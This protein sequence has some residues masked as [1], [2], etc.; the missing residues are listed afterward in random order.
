[1]MRK[2]G[3]IGYLLI[4]VLVA[5]CLPVEDLP[6]E[7]EIVFKSF[8]QEGT[9]ATLV[10]GFTD[11]DG[12]I[13]LEQGDTLGVN[14]PDTCIYYW[15]LFCEYY[16]LQD[17]EWTHIPIDWTLENS[18]PFYYRVPRAEPTGQNPALIGDISIDMPFYSLPSD[19]DTARFEV[20]LV[21]RDLNESNVITTSAFIKPD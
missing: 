18:I 10:F 1:M 6:P 11:G 14:C 5:S 20:K 13:G 16:E 12:N 17:G 7:P 3:S 15:N 21:D 4:V 9:G 2:I 8:T 19:Y